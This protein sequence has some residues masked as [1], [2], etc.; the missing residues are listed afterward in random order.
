MGLLGKRGD[1]LDTTKKVW[2]LHN[3]RGRLIV[4]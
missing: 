1:V 4:E 2:R 3:Q